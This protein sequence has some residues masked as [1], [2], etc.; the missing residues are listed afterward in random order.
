MSNLEQVTERSVHVCLSRKDEEV[1]KT[2]RCPSCKRSRALFY[3]WRQDWYGWHLT[4]CDCGEQFADGEWLERPWCPGW[5]EQNILK[6]LFCIG[7]MNHQVTEKG[8]HRHKYIKVVVDY[9]RGGAKSEKVCV[10]CHPIFKPTKENG[11]G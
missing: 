11:S 7:E 6:A 3:G 1:V 10:I 9:D 8:K 5:R 4:C 2:M